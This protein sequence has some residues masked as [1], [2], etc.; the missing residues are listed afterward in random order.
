M[1]I[2]VTCQV[3]AGDQEHCLT[4]RE[5]DIMLSFGT[6]RRALKELSSKSFIFCFNPESEGDEG[7]E[8]LNVQAKTDKKG[9][10]LQ[11]YIPINFILPV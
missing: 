5:Y 2:G 6:S 9:F 8:L 11:F 3:I 7:G 4:D 10:R 1:S